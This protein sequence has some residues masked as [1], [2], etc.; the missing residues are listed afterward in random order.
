V[1]ECV[2]QMERTGLAISVCCSTVPDHDFKLDRDH[3]MSRI[4]MGTVAGRFLDD[5]EIRRKQDEESFA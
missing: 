2:G 5:R 3:E 4:F 1:V